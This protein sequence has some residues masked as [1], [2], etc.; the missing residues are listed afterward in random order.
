MGLL[1]R[2]AMP[3]ATSFWMLSASLLLAQVVPDP[4]AGATV[5]IGDG[6]NLDVSQPSGFPQE[7]IAFDSAQC[8]AIQ[9]AGFKS[10]RF[11]IPAADE[12]EAFRPRIDEAIK[13]KLTVVICLW[14][15]PEWISNP[16]QGIKEFVAS[17]SQIAVEFK[18]YSNQLVFELL[19][20]PGALV[21]EKGKPDGLEDE[22][23]VMAFLNAAIPAIRKTNPNRILA[24]GGPGLNGGRELRDYVTP[25]YLTYRLA[26]GTGFAADRNIIG[27]FHMYEPHS[28]TH[29][30]KPLSE[31]PDWKT[32]VSEQFEHATS[33]SKRWDKTVML[34][35]WG[36]WKPPKHTVA[37]FRAYLAFVTAQC[38]NRKVI[39]MYYCAGFN[40]K[41]PFNILDSNTGWH[42]AALEILTG[43]A[44]STNGR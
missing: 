13:R 9:A 32:R 2:K 4:G 7:K 21:I 5:K 1:V 3:A 6:I 12:P 33:W 26:D 10:V 34:S 22:T 27:V 16:D 42:Q 39:S 15:K 43:S 41:W 35:E 17:W 31:I 24:I 44:K 29:W 20:E 19:N 11:F 37:D 38:R 18:D 36:A 25:T 28:F 30:T 14:G 8:D 23:L 40:D